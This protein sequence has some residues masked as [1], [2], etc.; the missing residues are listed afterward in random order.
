MK[1]YLIS[2]FIAMAVLSVPAECKTDNN[3]KSDV[4]ALLDQKNADR[5]LLVGFTDNTINSIKSTA[6]PT[7]YRQRGSYG[8]STWSERITNDL[9]EDYGLE[10]LSEWPMTAVGVHCVVYRVAGNDSVSSA[11]EKL[12]KDDRV[13]LVQNMNVF[14][15][16][17][18]YDK[19]PYFKLQT[20]LQ[21]MEISLA[22]GK[23]TGRNIT[24]GLI[25]TGVDFDH[26]D[27]TGQI[28]KNQNFA[29]E[30]SG[31][32]TTDIH[33]TAVAGVM[34]AKKDNAKGIIGVA[35]NAKVFALKACWPDKKDDIEAVCNSFTLAF[36]VNTAIKAGVDIL[37]MSLTGPQD[38]ILELLLKE[39]IAKGIIVV[40]A[41][42]GSGK[43]SE[44]FP[45][46]LK[47]VISVRSI[48]K[49][50]SL[51]NNISAPGDKIL[52]TL[53]HGTYDFISGSS[54]AAAEISGVVALLLE[55]KPNLT[56]T[57][58]HSVLQGSKL[59]SKDG[60]LAGVNANA[61]VNTLCETTT[62][63]NKLLGFALANPISN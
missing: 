54:I 19:D 15:T 6:S 10:K 4:Y 7:S 27:L 1:T 36:A 53:P 38:P 55:L 45:A 2:A 14:K 24:I 29:E 57:E 12:S 46:S 52:T 20:N 30:I 8:S 9:A 35:P 62:C 42:T 47:D 56:V 51:K 13:E 60:I 49:L 40:A 18:N 44:N 21:Q 58:A 50:D 34:V 25:D 11:I 22:H 63:A 43:T 16:R 31:S 3:S 37:N 5:L 26:P 59:L 33:G 61:A 48:N 17:A 23:A 39:A 28:S 41:D 32:F